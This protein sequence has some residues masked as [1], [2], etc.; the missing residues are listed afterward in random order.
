MEGTLDIQSVGRGTGWSSWL[1]P[2]RG[3]LA[4]CEGDVGV[5]RP[6][7]P[8]VIQ[9]NRVFREQN[10]SSLNQLLVYVGARASIAWL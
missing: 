3:T 2:G 6:A 8:V 4:A 10:H 1:S 9:A 5:S 7:G